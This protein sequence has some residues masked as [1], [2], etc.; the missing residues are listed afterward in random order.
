MHSI[1][2]LQE[3]TVANA[4]QIKVW[5]EV[6][7]P[8]LLPIRCALA[9]AALPFGLAALEALAP[10]AGERALDVGCGF[11]ETALELAR[12][13]GQAG[14]VVGIDV[15]EPYLALARREAAAFG[16]VRFLRGDAQIFPFQPEFDVCFS[17]FG[18][19]FFDDPPAAFANLR[20]A[21]RTGGRFAAVVWGPADT[22]AWVQM[23][24]QAVRARL[25]A[26][27]GPSSSGP[28]PFSLSDGAA[29]A[30][31]LL[32]AGFVGIRVRALDLP[33]YSGST[34]AKAASYLLRVGPAGAALREAGE[35]GERL[36]PQIERELRESLAPWAEPRGVELPSSVLLATASA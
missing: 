13:V 23:P 36:R 14:S 6:N 10:A 33:Y 7:P 35:A 1:R 9:A 17:R 16:N 26:A 34:P 11:G 8:R 19:M 2:S 22:C 20:R 29:L 27:A 24:L 32:G 18:V 21:L 28:G 12:R 30:R 5:N 25:P 15:G 4:A 31:L 3:P